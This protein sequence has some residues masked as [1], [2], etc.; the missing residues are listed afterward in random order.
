[1]SKINSLSIPLSAALFLAAAPAVA[2]VS[3]TDLWTEWQAQTAA[4]G[5]TITADVEQ[6]SDGLVLT[7]VTTTS[8]Q[9]GVTSTGRM[10]SITL[11]ENGDGTISVELSDVYTLTTDVV[12]EDENVGTMSFEMRHSGLEIT[13]SGDEANRR[14]DY[15][16]DSLTLTEGEIVSIDGSAPAIDLEVVVSDISA[17]Y[18]LAGADPATT[19]FTTE[20]QFGGATAMIDATAPPGEDGN[21]KFRAAMGET[22]ATGSGSLATINAL[23][24]LAETGMPENMDLAG[25][26]L[27]ASLSYDLQ[28]ASEGETV[29]MNMAN[30]GGRIAV[31][32]TDGSISYD[33]SGQNLRGSVQT[34]E[35]PFPVDMTAARTGFAIT[36]PLVPQPQPSDMALALSYEGLEVNDQIWAMFDPMQAIPRDPATLILDLTGSVQMLVN[37]MTAD[38]AE[39]NGPPGE[40]RDLTLNEL[41]VSAAGVQLEGDGDLDFAPGQTI[42][43]PVGAINLR[44]AGA[45]ALIDRLMQAGMLPPEQ[46]AMARGMAGMFARPGASPDT[47]ETV[48]EFLPGGGVTANG[49]PL[50]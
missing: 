31:G 9:Q 47:L 22:T 5:Q 6:V 17:I 32:F 30:D 15:S 10:D 23:A 12:V 16:A 34:S 1:M 25:E 14:Y 49:I 37:L 35:L 33:L 43:Q 27:Y 28:A 36:V 40:L 20:S 21:F 7:N 42:P 2:Q 38:P 50:Q 26:A 45:N 46:A 3:A 41:R 44:L 13:V 8:T 24:R 19:T 48:I 18:L 39:M 11:T 29:A 4:T